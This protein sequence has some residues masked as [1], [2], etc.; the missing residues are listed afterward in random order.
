VS[1]VEFAEHVK[2][3]MIDSARV[4]AVVD[5]RRYSREL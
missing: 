3:Q 4:V 1:A 2:Q 5:R